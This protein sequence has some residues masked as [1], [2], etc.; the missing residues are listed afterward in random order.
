[1]TLSVG[2]NSRLLS[3]GERFYA[4]SGIVQGDVSVPASVTLLSFESGLRDSF[5]KIQPSFDKP[6]STAVN[7]SLGL[8]ISIDGVEVYKSQSVDGS[9]RRN[10]ERNHEIEL[11]IPK[12]STVEVTSLNTSGNNTQGRGATLL[13]W[14]L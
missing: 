11:F 2:L 1:M 10:D 7:T 14:Y 5:I 6:A 8:S 4:Y 3:S 9:S 12:Q 13:G